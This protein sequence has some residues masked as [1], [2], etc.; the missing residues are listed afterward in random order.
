MNIP[1]TF[2]AAAL[3]FA[4]FSEAATVNLGT[5]STSYSGPG[6]TE[7]NTS[8]SVTRDLGYLTG[9][10][11][12]QS[13]QISFTAD[14]PTLWEGDLFYNAG[15]I[16]LNWQAQ[17][18]I[19]IGSETFTFSDLW[20]LS[21]PNANGGELG[22]LGIVPGDAPF[23]FSFVVPWGTDLDS[24]TIVLKDLSTV[25]GQGAAFTRSEMSISGTFVTTSVPEP[26]TALL[27]SLGSLLLTRRRRV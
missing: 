13:I 26:S 8:T 16:D 15:Q 19:S 1:C 23:S 6:A 17:I 20:E 9:L 3:S 10:I 14:M 21:S 12:G 2:I 11:P 4:S 27:G 5:L 24:V 18:E 22:V 7:I 25:D